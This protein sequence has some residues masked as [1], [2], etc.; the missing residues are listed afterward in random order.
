MKTITTLAVG[1]YPCKS[2]TEIRANVR[3]KM[4]R[5]RPEEKVDCL[6]GGEKLSRL[7]SNLLIALFAWRRGPHADRVPVNINERISC[8]ISQR[9]NGRR[10]QKRKEQKKKRKEREGR[11]M[12]LGT[13]GVKLPPLAVRFLLH[14]GHALFMPSQYR[15]TQAL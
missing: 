9:L 11:K 1:D 14:G 8:E 12:D 15:E 13:S 6:R 10:W 3:R 2:S 4:L 7:H 5:A